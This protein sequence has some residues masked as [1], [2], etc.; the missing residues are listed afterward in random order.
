M[1]ELD[2]NKLR[3]NCKLVF[4]NKVLETNDFCKNDQNIVLLDK[5]LSGFKAFSSKLMYYEI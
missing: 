3:I 2:S 5:L 4:K 1:L